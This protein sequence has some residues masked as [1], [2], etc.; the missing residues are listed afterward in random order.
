MS[1]RIEALLTA[2]NVSD[3]QKTILLDENSTDEQVLNALNDYKSTYEA[4]VKKGILNDPEWIKGIKDDAYKKA[5]GEQRG[6]ADRALAGE[7]GLKASDLEGK[8]WRDKASF[9]SAHIKQSAGT[10]DSEVKKLYQ[11]LQ[12]KY[13]DLEEKSNGFPD[14]LAARDKEWEEKFAAHEQA[15]Q[16]KGV[17]RNTFSKFAPA[18]KLA[19]PHLSPYIEAEMMDAVSSFKL[20]KDEA[21]VYKL[22]TEAGT[23][24][25]NAAG[26]VMDTLEMW[27]EDYVST[28]NILK[29]NN[30][31]NAPDPATTKIEV[32]KT[33]HSGNSWM[34][35]RQ[36][37][38]TARKE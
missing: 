26:K 17:L 11:E 15:I 21:G 13:A 9:L 24:P 25:K 27:M 10:E 36:E 6:S 14:Q 34:H 5:Q 3:E 37:A 22:E 31:G 35:K 33:E 2:L 1:T 32:K 19:M 20:G 7:F 12:K 8:N 30:G 18:D 29:G 23:L 4:D 38:A 28:K 16:R